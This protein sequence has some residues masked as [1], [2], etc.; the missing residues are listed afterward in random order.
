[1]GTHRE[2]RIYSKKDFLFKF[3]SFFSK[4][5]ST[6]ITR[7]KSI[8]VIQKKTNGPKKRDLC[9]TFK[10]CLF[11]VYRNAYHLQEAFIFKKNTITALYKYVYFAFS[12][13]YFKFLFVLP[14]LLLVL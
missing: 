13:L 6:I 4:I 2:K 3:C 10:E 12:L 7:K 1:M 9:A 11:N 8:N 5:L 14:P